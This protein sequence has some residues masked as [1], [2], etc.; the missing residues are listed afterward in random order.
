MRTRAAS[1]AAARVAAVVR[2]LA[3]EAGVNVVLGMAG[4]A[5][6]AE[7]L[8]LAALH[9]PDG[10]LDELHWRAEDGRVAFRATVAWPQV[11][12]AVE[13]GVC[14][15]VGWVRG[16]ARLVKPEGVTL[17]EYRELPRW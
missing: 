14:T 4:R 16:Y 5:I 10:V 1:S 3:V 13:V 9:E 11:G 8:P 7:A 15:R 17:R 12:G 2:T 6:L